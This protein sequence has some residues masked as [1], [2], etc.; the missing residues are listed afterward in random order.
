MTDAPVTDSN[1][2]PAAPGLFPAT[3]WTLVQRAIGDADADRQ[4]AL[5]DLLERYWR[6]IY[7]YLRHSGR[8]VAEAEDLTQAFFVHMLEKQLLERVRLR[9]VRFRAYL[10]SVLEHFLANEARTARAKKRQGAITFDIAGAESWLAACPQES[11]ESAFD[12]I[13]AVERLQT[14]L[15]RLRQELRHAGREWVAEAMM[16]RI[17]LGPAPGP[18]P[19]RDLACRHGV[20]ENQLSV[21]LHRARERLRELILDEIRDCVSSPEEAAQELREMFAAL[22]KRPKGNVE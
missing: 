22:R 21:A 17:G 20:T 11:P 2:Q 1:D 6:P 3:A 9:Q 16:N 7:I 15:E 8:P 18:S 13:W 12:G 5:N 14:A 10:R 19:V 4:T